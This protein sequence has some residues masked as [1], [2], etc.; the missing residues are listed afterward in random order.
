MNVFVSRPTWVAREYE[1][2]IE[3]FIDYL[4]RENFDPHTLGTTDFP[5][6]S[7][8]DEVIELMKNSTGVIVLGY[9]QIPRSF[10]SVT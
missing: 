4:K 3:A 10:Q 2:G 6:E 9:P 1:E 5:V 7:P 8:L